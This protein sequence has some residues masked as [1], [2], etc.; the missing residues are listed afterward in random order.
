[1]RRAYFEFA[2]MLK[3]NADGYF[4]YTPPTPLLH[5]LRAALDRSFREGLD[6][7][8][9]RHH[10]IWPRACAGRVHAWGLDLGRASLASTPTPSRPSA[11]PRTSM[12]ATCCASPMRI[13]NTSF[14]SGLARLAGKVFRIGHL[15]DFNEG[16]ALTALSI[17]EMSLVR[18]GRRCQLGAGVAPR[19]WFHGRGHGQ[20]RRARRGRIS[21][22]GTCPT[23]L[24]K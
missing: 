21:R 17:A 4:P 11:R 20:P 22:P 18:A 5:G 12:P 8:I 6:E 24:P 15:G 2:D 10:R 3:M 13:M 7:V 1:M 23:K 19:S 9:A 14:G 16:M